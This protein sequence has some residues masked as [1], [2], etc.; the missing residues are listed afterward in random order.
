[1]AKILQ[2][3][4]REQLSKEEEKILLNRHLDLCE[5]DLQDAM[6]MLDDLNEEIVVLTHEYNSILMRLKE[7]VL[8][9]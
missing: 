4:T 7:L 9:E 3:P 6:R 2:F 8:E 1:M 5:T